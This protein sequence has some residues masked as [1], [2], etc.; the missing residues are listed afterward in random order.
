MYNVDFPNAGID[1]RDQTNSAV[2]DMINADLS[3]AGYPETA[4]IIPYFT[5]QIITADIR[6]IGE[7][8]DGDNR[9]SYLYIPTTFRDNESR[10]HLVLFPGAGFQIACTLASLFVGTLGPANIIESPRRN[11]NISGLNTQKLNITQVSVAPDGA[12]TYTDI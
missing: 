8:S 9:T 4:R 12:I 7:N 2:V 5:T 11:S 6:V 3:K 10:P 1:L